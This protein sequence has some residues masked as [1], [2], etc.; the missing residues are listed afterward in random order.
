MDTKNPV[1]NPQPG[2]PAEQNA[3]HTAGLQ[4]GRNTDGERIN[5]HQA[6]YGALHL[7]LD[8]YRSCLEFETEHQLTA[9]PLRIDMLII[10]KRPEIIIRKNIGVIF[11]Q[12]NVIEF[13]SPDDYISVDDFYK[14]MAY[15]YLYAAIERIPVTRL[16]LTLAWSGYPRNAAEHGWE[17][18]ERESGKVF[19]VPAY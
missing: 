3:A 7:E 18:R 2:Q 10:K 15:C 17:V 5:W 14:T 8:E 16:S 6:F 1:T 13:K 19:Y 9:E 12:D 11:R 4:T